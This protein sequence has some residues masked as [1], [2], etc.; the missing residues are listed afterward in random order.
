M[1]HRNSL[2]MSNVSETSS[3][4]LVERVLKQNIYYL[5]YSYRDFIHIEMKC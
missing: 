4:V 5:F 3:D 2:H 1:Y